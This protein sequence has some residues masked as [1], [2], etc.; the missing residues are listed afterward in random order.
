MTR[1]T[2]V[3]LATTLAFYRQNPLQALF[4]L[5]GLVLGCGLYTA[6]AQINASAK[7][8]YAQADEILGASAQWRITDR[9]STDV[10]I[11]DYIQLRRAGF[12]SVYP[13]VEKRLVSRD[14]ALISIIATDLLV[15]PS[16]GTGGYSTDGSDFEESPFDSSGWSRLTQFPYQ[17]WV[18]AQTAERLGVTEG[19]Q[20]QLRE[21]TVLPPAVIRSQPQQRDQIFIDLGAALSIFETDR[22]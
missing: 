2:L 5:T 19:Q 4:V 15:L 6:V 9:V 16:T 13:V 10:A 22:V 18:P 17:A 1:A 21:G 11:D 7:A 3:T 14:G 12:T 20:I 8:S